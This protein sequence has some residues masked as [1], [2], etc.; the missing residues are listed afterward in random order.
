MRAAVPITRRILPGDFTGFPLSGFFPEKSK[1][2]IF[3]ALL[4]FLLAGGLTWVAYPLRIA[5]ARRAA[6][7][8]ASRPAVIFPALIASPGAVYSLT[9]PIFQHERRLPLTDCPAA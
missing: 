7:T 4:R 2:I 8:R 3:L 9:H 5:S 6:R 1:S